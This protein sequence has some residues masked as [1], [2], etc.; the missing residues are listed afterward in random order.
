MRINMQEF[1][2]LPTDKKVEGLQII[3]ESLHG[4]H[5]FASLVLEYLQADINFEDPVLESMYEVL[6]SLF[7]K[8]GGVVDAVI[9]QKAKELKEHIQRVQEMEKREHEKADEDLLSQLDEIE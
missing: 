7:E 8:A 3:A 2:I 1:H 9:E 5:D 6:F 4:Q